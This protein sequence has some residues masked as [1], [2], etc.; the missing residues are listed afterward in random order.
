MLANRVGI[1]KENN[2][3]SVGCYAKQ[4]LFVVHRLRYREM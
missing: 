2:I 4:Q 1:V 3:D